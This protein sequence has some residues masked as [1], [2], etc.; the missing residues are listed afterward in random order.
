MISAR[1]IRST[2]RFGSLLTLLLPQQISTACG[3]WV[4]PNEFRFWMLQP[5]IVNQPE[6]TPF[7]LS[8]NYLYNGDQYAA[9]ETF[10]TENINEWYAELKGQVPK[11]DIDSFMYHT[12]PAE[13]FTNEARLVKDNRLWKYASNSPDK[14]IRTYLLLSKRVEEIAANPD[15]W[16]ERSFPDAGINKVIADLTSFNTNCK[17]AFLKFR[18]AYQLTRLYGYNENSKQVAATYDKLIAP[19]NSKSWV[20]TAALYQKAIRSSGHQ[21]DYLLSK[22]FDLGNFQKTS[23]LVRFNSRDINNIMPLAKNQHEKNVL[24]AMKAFNYAGRSLSQLKA[25]YATEPAYRELPFLLLR[26]I[27][28]VEDWIITNKVTEFGYPATH[29]DSYD[30]YA[31]AD[32]AKE[33]YQQDKA[34]AKELYA[35]VVS[36]EQNKSVTRQPLLALYAS[37]LALL[38]G[39]IEKATSFL[40]TAKKSTHQPKNIQT[41]IAINELLINLEKNITS[42]VEKQFMH[43][44]NTSNEETG[45]YDPKVM[46]SQ[47]ALYMSNKMIAN[48]NKARGLMLL[49]RTDR[50]FGQLGSMGYK[51]VYQVIEE[52]ANNKDYEEILSI[53]DK[54]DKS[55]FESFI[56]TKTFRSP[57]DGYSDDNEKLKWDRNKILDGLSSW[58]IREHRLPEALAVLK[59]IPAEVWSKYPY[60]EYIGGNAFYLNVYQSASKGPEEKLSYN[61]VEVIEK[62]IALEQMA[63]KYKDKAA[64]CYFQLANAW[65]NMT[66]WGKN[67]LMVKQWWSSNELFGDK[68][69]KKIPNSPEDYFECRTARA[70]YQKALAAT[71]DKKLASLCYFMIEQC[72]WRKKSFRA[73]DASFEDQVKH[74]KQGYTKVSSKGVDLNYYKQLVEECEL[75]QSFIKQYDRPL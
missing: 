27:N 57:M 31:Y 19:I 61:K 69:S 42:D 55:S 4:S 46:K 64:V 59:K 73:G 8:A 53:L 35:F 70:Y 63:I 7:F 66:Y 14:E 25:I 30:R 28:K 60:S 48:G 49:S 6:L 21:Y 3:F 72:D 10:Y 5:D 9:V 74:L 24:L 32:K 75:Y 47:L 20:K 52:K 12:A 26:E 11:S 56:S 45:I 17:S 34:Y 58:Y 29:D 38:N 18:S 16:E 15:P 2:I 71:T 41:Q 51:T 54:K 39:D 40:A 13:L 37:H 50:A 1:W 33:N 67:W 62:M 23:C 44:V 68:P 43:I 22:V 36:M 65:Y